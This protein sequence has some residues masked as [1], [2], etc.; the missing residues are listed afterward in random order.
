MAAFFFPH[1][2]MTYNTSLKVHW[3]LSPHLRNPGVSA[4]IPKV[5]LKEF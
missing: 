5:E 3:S 1:F 2:C 4:S